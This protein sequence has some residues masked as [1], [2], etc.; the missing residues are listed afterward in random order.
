[1][2]DTQTM[3]G[4][5]MSGYGIVKLQ[6][7]RNYFPLIIFLLIAVLSISNVYLSCRLIDSRHKI[8]QLQ[9]DVVAL[10]SG[11]LDMQDAYAELKQEYPHE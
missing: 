6:K 7:E 9:G 3:E 5:E 10:Q 11:I 1:M 2:R 4:G 8:R